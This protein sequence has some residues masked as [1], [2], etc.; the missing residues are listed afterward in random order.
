MAV[1]ESCR[2]E[3]RLLIGGEWSDAESG[4]HFAVVNPATNTVVGSV[5]DGSEADVTRAIAAAD[6]A[7]DGWR[8]RAARMRARILRRAADIVSGRSDAIARVMTAEQGEPLAEA[9]AEVEYAGAFSSGSE[10]RP[11]ACTDRDAVDR[12]AKPRPRSATAARCGRG[13]HT[14]EPFPPR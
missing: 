1:A 2:L 10:A 14:L 11:S 8:S 9:V 13:D 5:A 4:K 6:A 3:E 7:L 12:P